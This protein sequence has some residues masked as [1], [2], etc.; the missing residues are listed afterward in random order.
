MAR[1][2]D[3]EQRER[4]FQDRKVRSRRI[5]RI[6]G[7]ARDD[8]IHVAAVRRVSL[9]LRGCWLVS[10]H[11]RHQSAQQQLADLKHDRHIDEYQR[12]VRKIERVEE[13]RRE[14]RA[15]F[16]ALQSVDDQFRMERESIKERIASGADPDTCMR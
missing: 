6:R 9:H 7:R 2:K 14:H 16:T 5:A 1:L 15:R 3:D 13:G 11:T 8:L 10:S 12:T 4:A